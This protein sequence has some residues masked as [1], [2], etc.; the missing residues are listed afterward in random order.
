MR[1]ET[2]Q[3][4]TPM[5]STPAVN[6]PSS[7]LRHLAVLLFATLLLA[8]CAAPNPAA[9]FYPPPPDLPRL[10]F[11]K[12]FSGVADLQSNILKKAL[13]E[14]AFV[15]KKAYGVAFYKDKLYVVDSRLKGYAVV[16]LSNN[17]ITFISNDP[18]K[19]NSHFQHPFNIAIAS[20][21]TKY[22][23]DIA[24]KRVLAYSADDHYLRS[25]RFGKES[26]PLGVAVMNNKL[27]VTDVKK[28]SLSIIDI[29]SGETLGQI[30]EK[31]KLYWPTTLAIGPDHSIYVTD[32]GHFSVYKFTSA[33]KFVKEYGSIGDS[34]GNFS[35]PKGI[36][37]TRDNYIYVIDS[38]FENVQMFNQEGRPLLYFSQGGNRSEDLALPAGIAISYELAPLF[39]KYAADG[40]KIDHIV[41]VTSQ[42]GPS[43]I[44]IYGYG[45]QE[46]A[47]YSKYEKK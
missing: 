4:F 43:K 8:G 37:I 26:G 34:V 46:G 38:A 12:S 15:F 44:N 20:D 41:A 7:H 45:K 21:G 40:F 23:S 29:E 35:R 11:L 39:Q 1:P 5:P 25:Y 3:E 22:I 33:G 24:Q 10:Q 14:D 42:S 2:V 28:H 9:I 6:I 27:Y 16:D 36:A 17:K 18:E 19:R 47:D 30:G 13:S 31:E 32:T